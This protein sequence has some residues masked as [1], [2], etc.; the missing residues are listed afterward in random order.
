MKKLFLILTMILLSLPV[1]A[2]PTAGSTLCDNDR[3][4][5]NEL[6]EIQQAAKDAG[7]CLNSEGEQIECTGD[8][9]PGDVIDN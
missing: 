2:D 1:L 3:T 4:T 6:T 9:N 7:K 8:Y 5:Q